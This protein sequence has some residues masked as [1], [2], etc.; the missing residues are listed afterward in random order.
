MDY[1]RIKKF[2]IYVVDNK[3][4]QFSICNLQ[5]ELISDIPLIKVVYNGHILIKAWAS[6]INVIL[7]NAP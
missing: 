7:T 6:N 5:I 1:L 4:E 3:K 2:Q